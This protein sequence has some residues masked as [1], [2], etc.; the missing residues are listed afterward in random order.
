MLDD[1]H[2]AVMIIAVLVI[3]FV[4]LNAIYEYRK[5]PGTSILTAFSNSLTILWT[6]FRIAVT[7]AVAF[8]ASAAS[9]LNLPGVS[10]FIHTYATPVT[11]AALLM[12]A[13]V[14]TELARRRN[15]PTPPTIPPQA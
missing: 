7:A 10:T 9:Y 12:G 11:V 13:D 14:V 2:I 5:T 4:V 8:L 1:I 15:L 3:G 6:R